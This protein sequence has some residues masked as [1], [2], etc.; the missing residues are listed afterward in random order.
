MAVVNSAEV[1]VRSVFYYTA[2]ND[3]VVESVRY[4]PRHPVDMTLPL[5]ESLN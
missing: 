4:V 3:C 2:P 5:L 1:G